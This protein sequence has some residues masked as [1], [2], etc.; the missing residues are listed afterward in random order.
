MNPTLPNP[1]IDAYINANPAPGTKDYSFVNNFGGVNNISAPNPNAAINNAPNR[2]PHS[3]VVT[4][5]LTS[6]TPI[7]S[8]S[9]ASTNPVTVA[10]YTPSTAAAGLAGTIDAQA[11]QYGQSVI[12]QAK[13][14]EEQNTKKSQTDQLKGL[15]D[16]L[17][18]K[19]AATEEA[20]KAEGV[21]TAKTNL[22]DINNQIL[23]EQNGL[24]HQKE[25]IYN[26][27]GVTREAANNQFSEVQ[28]ISLGK[29]ADLS[30][31]QYVAQNRYSDA[32]AIADR[33]IEMQFEPIQTKLDAL[34][35]FYSENKDA[36]SKDEDKQF[37][38]TIAERSRLL[39]DQKEQ[40]KTL[41]DTKLAILKSANEN[42]APVSIQQ[43]IQAAKTPEEAISLAGRYGVDALRTAQIAN[44][45][46]EIRKRDAET[47]ELG[48][49]E[50]TN[51]NVAPYAGALSVILGSDKF[52]KD[53]RKAVISAINAGSDPFS[54]VKNQAKNIMGQTEATGLTKLEVARDTLND[55]GDQLQAFYAAGGDTGI[56]TGNFEKTINKLGEVKDPKLV[57][58]ATQIQGNIQVYR[59]AISGT[60]YSAQEGKDINS[61]FPGINKSET[62][63]NAILNGRSRLFDSVIDATYRSTLGKS[64]DQLKT[65]QI[66]DPKVQV[67]AYIKATPAEAEAVAKLYDVP[68]ATDQDIY[69]YLKKQGK[70]K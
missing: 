5:T 20:Y 1:S 58:L 28:R 55:I 2:D 47:K 42:G 14:T 27:P 64:Y 11:K 12:D 69:D 57:A 63:N 9:L 3:G 32:K 18:T 49:P 68:G 7:T 19:G 15:F 70:I 65:A 60:A 56:F 24:N 13:L 46:S 21:D 25:S 45:N 37:Q 39:T 40:A 61:I 22:T 66:Q 54:V 29:Q 59:N 8:G 51:G 33:K 16:E 52:T 6:G 36:L 4:P 17:A 38:A 44:L 34:K 53:Q 43:A 41:Q 10:S 26:A 23:A 35:F 48:T 31:I 50:I 62:L 30:V 67:D